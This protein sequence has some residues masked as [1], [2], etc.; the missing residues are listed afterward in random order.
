MKKIVLIILVAILSFLVFNRIGLANNGFDLSNA[1][2]PAALIMGGGPPKDGI[3]SLD[4]PKFIFVNDVDFLQ[5]TDRVLGINFQGIIKAYPIKIMNYHEVVNDNFNSHPVAITFCPLCRSGIAYSAN[6]KGKKHSFGVSGLLYNSD[7]LLYD[8]ETESLWSQI[9]S[10]AISGPLK[11]HHLTAIPMQNT[12][13]QDWKQQHPNTLVL[14]TETGYRRDYT[15]SP[16]VGYELDNSIWFPVAA[17]NNSYH[18]KSLVLGIEIEGKFKAYPFS[19]LEKTNGDLSD[20]FV[21]KNLVIRFNKQY[22]N[23]R[24]LEHQGEELPSIVTF[25]FAWYAFHPEGLVFTEQKQ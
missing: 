14:S 3:P 9:M 20:S 10:T 22:Q 17:Q 16:Y 21:G 12:T 18:P 19:E 15:S 24:V 1:S 13:W 11:D 25:W 7:V 5:N 8:R 23:A 4:N 6:I 2:V